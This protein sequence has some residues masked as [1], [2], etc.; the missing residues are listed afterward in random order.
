MDRRSFVRSGLAAGAALSFGSSFW[1]TVL[2]EVQ[3]GPSPYGPL[4]APD[5]NGLRLPAGFT[6]RVIARS[7]EP[8][9][10]TA[11]VWHHFPDGGATFPTGDGGWVYTSN[12]ETP[13][14]GGT[15]AVK[16]AKDGTIVDAYRILT[17][18]AM[19]CA[20]GPTP[21]GT[22]LSC[23]EW[24]GGNVWECNPFAPGQGVARPALGSFSHEAVAV[25]WR[26]RRL[27]L[28]EDQPDGCFYRFTPTVW[29]DLSAGRLE[30]MVVSRRGLVSWVPVPDPNPASL[31]YQDRY[32]GTLETPTR[33]QVDAAR[34]DGGEGC[35]YDRSHVYFTT[36]GDSRVWDLDVGSNRLRVLYDGEATGGPLGGVDNVVVNRAGEIFVAEDGDNMQICVIA[37]GTVAPVLEMTGDAHYQPLPP[38][39]DMSEVTGP[40][41][42][43]DGRRLY[44]SSERWDRR[45]ITYEITGHWHT[46]R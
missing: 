43:P 42:S 28:T 32:G 5:A 12:S 29:P 14:T 9:P 35:W 23:E 40:A 38:L 45:G 44:C 18:T 36:K 7:D 13:G 22:W 41:F 15:G 30:A 10:G 33:H 6:S 21:W 3:P 8:V 39:S 24:D 25:D 37:G 1:R 16:F 17:G 4:Q 11:Y 34:F 2:A 19:N 46:T 20:G 27:Y 31:P 26:K